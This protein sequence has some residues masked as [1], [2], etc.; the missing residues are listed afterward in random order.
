MKQIILLFVLSLL[1]TSVLASPVKE[2]EG[3]KLYQDDK[4]NIL[5]LEG[6]YRE[7]GR[8]YGGLVKDQIKEFYKVAIEERFIKKQQ[9]SYELMKGFSAG[10][11]ALYPKRLKEISYGISETSGVD[12][13]KLIIL[14]SILGLTFLKAEGAEGGNCSAL[15]AWD[16]YTDGPLVI[17]RNYDSTQFFKKEFAPYLNLVIYKPIDGV[18]TALLNY[19][20]EITSF[21]GMNAA[22]I[23]YEDNEAVKSGGADSPTDRLVLYPSEVT[24]LLDYDNFLSFDAA[25]KTNLSNFAFI[26][27]IATKDQAYSYE[28]TTSATK[29][30]TGPGLFAAT[31][32]FV[33][34]AWNLTP[35]YDA[36]DKSVQRREHLL[37]LGEENKGKITANKMMEIFDTSFASGGATWPERTAYQVVAVPAELVLWL[38]LP[39]YQDWIKLDLGSP[40][41]LGN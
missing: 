37:K 2:F 34:P 30:R 7:M 18:P 5:V 1:I 32:D 27:N 24:F 28:M 22:G 6:S 8:Q 20:G 12:L 19:A 33:D 38:K 9:V 35:P 23:F 25:M 40:E 26:A 14:E 17:G 15:A 10:A 21:T 13:D 41:R 39:D 16:D 3:G 11:F 36:A 31:N 4:I 29:R